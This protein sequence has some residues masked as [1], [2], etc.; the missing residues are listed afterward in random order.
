MLQNLIGY[1]DSLKA[2]DPSARSRWE[3]LLYAGV[4]A[5]VWHRVAHWFYTLEF[6]WLARLLSQIGRL[7]TGIEIHPGANIGKRFFIDHGMGVVI[8]ETAEIGDDVTMYHGVTLGGVD[9]ASGVGGKR[10]PTIAT[11]VIIGSGAQ[12]LGPI[13][14]GTNARVGANAVV[15][16]DVMPAATVVGIPAKP[17]LMDAVNFSR[18]FLAYGTPCDERYDPQSQ[19]L[20]IIRCEMEKLQARLAGLE[21]EQR[22]TPRRTGS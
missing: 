7:L 13:T 21:S 14:I 11:G 9:P 10:H 1:L 15:T 4:W 6:Y 3:I 2:R 17:I 19:R 22:E 16:R 12:I 20:E 18:E 5:L 8:G